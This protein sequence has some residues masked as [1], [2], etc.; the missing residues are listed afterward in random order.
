[1]NA[2][3][4]ALIALMFA[5]SVAVA[6]AVDLRSPPNLLPS[7]TTGSDLTLSGTSTAS[8]YTATASGDFSF[9]CSGD[10]PYCLYASS[11]N[12]NM[13]IISNVSAGNAGATS[14]TAMTTVRPVNALDATDWVLA[15]CDSAGTTCSYFQHNGIAELGGNCLS[16][17]GGGVGFRCPT[18]T[19]TNVNFDMGANGAFRLGT[20]TSNFEVVNLTDSVQ[21]PTVVACSGTAASVTASNGTAAFQFDVGTS[22]AGESTAVITLPTA[23]TGWVCSCSST[24]ADRILQQKVMPNASTTQVTMQNIVIS[25]GANGDFTDGADVACMCRGM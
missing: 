14:A 9:T 13:L 17:G 7:G 10:D 15:V 2:M 19:A 5:V 16:A 1:M 6:G 8:K 24:T 12:G 21:T 18:A 25:T 4:G 22:C 23:T 11:S 20:G 3:K